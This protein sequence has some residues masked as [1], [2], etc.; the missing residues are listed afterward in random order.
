MCEASEGRD[1]LQ[2]LGNVLN[3]V[4]SHLALYQLRALVAIGLAPGI[5]VNELSDE[6]G[7]PQQTASRYVGGLLGRYGDVL[8]AGDATP[9]IEQTVSASD[10]RRRA[11]YLSRD[12]DLLLRHIT[13]LLYD[14]PEN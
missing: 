11:L 8:S 3:A 4:P 1:D 13:S 2:R 9:L 10:P 14:S 7:V 6:L 5:S 12:G